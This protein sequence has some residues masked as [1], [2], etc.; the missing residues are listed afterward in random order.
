MAKAKAN[1]A[2]IECYLLWDHTFIYNLLVI[3]YLVHTLSIDNS[4]N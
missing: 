4:L 1:D 3:I 2:C